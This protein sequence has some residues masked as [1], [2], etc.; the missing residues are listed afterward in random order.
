[1]SVLVLEG[2]D[3]G[4]TE[5]KTLTQAVNETPSLLYTTGQF[6]N[7][8]SGKTLEQSKALSG[9]ALCFPTNSSNIVFSGVEYGVRIISINIGFCL[10]NL[11]KRQDLFSLDKVFDRISEPYELYK[12]YRQNEGIRFIGHYDDSLTYNNEVSDTTQILCECQV[13]I[14]FDENQGVF[15]FGIS[16]NR[17]TGTINQTNFSRV[18]LMIGGSYNANTFT[19]TKLLY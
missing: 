17:L 14:A 11:D 12:I 16:Y 10:D 2:E 7:F 4:K 6:M 8:Y 19:I 18:F 3:T 9:N 5:N 1:M 15:R 13:S